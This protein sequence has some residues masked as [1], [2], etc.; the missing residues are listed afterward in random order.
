M[1]NFFKILE[2]L[3]LEGGG[4]VRISNTFVSG[5][6][7]NGKATV[8]MGVDEKAVVDLANKDYFPMLILIDKKEFEKKVEEWKNL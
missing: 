6:I 7:D 5:H 4:G 2:E 1:D 3:K 8:I